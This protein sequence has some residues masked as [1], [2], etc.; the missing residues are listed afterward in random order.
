MGYNVTVEAQRDELLS[1]RLLWSPPSP[2]CLHNLWRNF[3]RGAHARPHFIRKLECIGILR[4]ACTD[5]SIFR[6]GCCRELAKS[7]STRFT[8]GFI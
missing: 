8:P 1:L 7:F 6:V 4:D 3:G 2:I 5:L